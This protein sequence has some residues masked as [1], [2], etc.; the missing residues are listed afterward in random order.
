MLL[1]ALTFATVG[2]VALP[3]NAIG[4][5]RGLTS[6]ERGSDQGAVDLIGGGACFRSIVDALDESGLFSFSIAAFRWRNGG[7][8][9]RRR[10]L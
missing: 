4:N 7:M 5:G 2:G 10:A 8:L 3:P 6:R 9:I 1:L